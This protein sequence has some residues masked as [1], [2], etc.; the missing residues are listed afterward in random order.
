M[1]QIKRAKSEDIPF[2][3]KI[4]LMAESTGYEITSYEKMFGQKAE[5]LIPIF[6]KILANKLSGFPLAVDSYLIAF[7]DDQPVAAISVYVEGEN[8]DS[9]HLMTGALMSGFDRKSLG[10]AFAFLKNNH[11][12]SIPKKRG[13]LQIDCVATF[14]EFRGK[15]LLK[16]LL[17][18]A[19]KLAQEKNCSELQIQVWKKNE[20]AVKAYEK[21]GFTVTE[22]RLSNSDSTNGKIL[23]TKHL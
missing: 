19:E 16:E 18:E 6:E 7:S 23:I 11:E 1:I 15:G 10:Q 13:S 14:P 5:D 22:E 2:I 8:G 21:L 17:K 9:N 4:V 3:A 20:N 12:L